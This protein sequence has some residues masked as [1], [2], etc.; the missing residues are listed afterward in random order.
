MRR[1]VYSGTLR[2]NGEENQTTLI[3]AN[4]Y[5]MNLLDL[6]RFKEVKSLLRRVM[7][8]ARRVLG[9]CDGT[10]LTMRYRYASAVCVDDD[11]T[12]DDFREAVA[13]LGD[14]ERTARRVLGG[15]HPLTVG[16]E[17]FLRNARTTLR[18]G[19]LS[20]IRVVEEMAS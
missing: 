20:A 15:A 19:G 3:E 14:A 10:T 17:K 9:D 2:L 13:T 16:I 4:N 8:V 12:L 5:A 1:D 18:D 11:V 7:P 6:R